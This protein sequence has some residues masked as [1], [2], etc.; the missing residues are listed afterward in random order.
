VTITRADAAKPAAAS[1][2]RVST[3]KG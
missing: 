3:A 1:R 2:G